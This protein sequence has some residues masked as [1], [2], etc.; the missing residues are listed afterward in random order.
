MK[1]FLETHCLQHNFWG[2]LEWMSWRF[3]CDNEIDKSRSLLLLLQVDKIVMPPRNHT[4]LKFAKS[5]E[6]HLGFHLGYFLDRLIGTK[7]NWCGENKPHR[8]PL[9]SMTY[10]RNATT[11]STNLCKTKR[12]SKSKCYNLE[13]KNNVHLICGMDGKSSD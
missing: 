1:G 7:P 4:A 11:F 6:W 8:R 5:F 12:T 13:K 10:R 9:A 3:R 2:A